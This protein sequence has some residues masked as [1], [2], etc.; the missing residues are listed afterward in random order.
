MLLS[1]LV[2]DSQGLQTIHEVTVK[3]EAIHTY[4]ALILLNACKL[5]NLERLVVC[6]S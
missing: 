3:L 1:L 2:V 4:T 6:R 5:N